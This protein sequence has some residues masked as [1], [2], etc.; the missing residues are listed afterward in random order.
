MAGGRIVGTMSAIAVDRARSDAGN[1]SGP[2]VAFALWQRQPGDLL[3]S[4]R[5]EEAELN[6]LRMGRED[7]EMGARANI[8]RPELRLE[9]V[10]F[11]K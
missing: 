2:D 3:L 10:E 4:I 9:E 1:I 7:G 5:R 6:L 8:F 11:R